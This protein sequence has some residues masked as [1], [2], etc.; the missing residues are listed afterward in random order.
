MPLEA[1]G[2]L[3]EGGGA[4]AAREGHHQHAGGRRAAVGGGFFCGTAEHLAIAHRAGGQAIAGPLG[5]HGLHGPAKAMGGGLDGA[6]GTTGTAM[7]QKLHQ[8][9]S[10]G[11]AEGG[12]DREGRP[13][14]ITA[15]TG[16]HHQGAAMGAG[17]G[18][19]QGGIR[20]QAKR[21][22]RGRIC[23]PWK[24]QTHGRV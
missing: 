23:G 3:Q 1:V 14:E 10:G 9:A 15:T 6:I 18:V 11:G 20:Q 8:A 21:R 4:A 19:R 2:L 24:E 17:R 5:G 13:I 12:S 7:E 22:L 16:Y